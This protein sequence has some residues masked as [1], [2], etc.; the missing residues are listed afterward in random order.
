M[1]L[2]L[3]NNRIFT[4]ICSGCNVENELK[5]ARLLTDVAFQTEWML[6]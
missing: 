3:G 6:A 1:F 2:P 5:R 4:K